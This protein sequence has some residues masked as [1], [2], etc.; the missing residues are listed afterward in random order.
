MKDKDSFESLKKSFSVKTKRYA[1]R[2][3]VIISSPSWFT[4]NFHLEF[5][6]SLHSW[7]RSLL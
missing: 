1:S 2:I 4:C 3:H 6:M 5:W 7:K